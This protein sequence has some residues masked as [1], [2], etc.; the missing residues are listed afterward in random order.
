MSAKVVFV[1]GASGFLG[2]HIVEQLLSRGYRVRVSA[3]GKKAAIL[4][5][6]YSRNPAVE[7]FEISDIIHEQ[8][9]EALQGVDAVIHAASPLPG[10]ME[11]EQML[12]TAIEGSL[13]VLRQAE[14]AGVKRFVVTSSVA[15][16]AGNPN[17]TFKDTD[18]NPVT[19]EVAINAGN[20]GVTYAASK[21]FA[22]LA[23]TLL[24]N[25]P[26]NT[27]S[28]TVNPPFLYGPFTTNF[29]TPDFDAFST[30]LSIYNLIK[31][32][33]KYPPRPGYAD[34]RDVARAH[35]TA[36]DSPP[37]SEVGRKRVIFASPYDFNFKNAI[38][39]LSEK[40]P[41]LKGRL[42]T[43][44]PPELPAYRYPVDFERIERVTGLKKG[45]FH[46][47]EK[48]LLDTVDNLLDVEAGWKSQ[49]DSVGDI[50]SFAGV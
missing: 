2:S 21:K 34:V 6:T 13:N 1:S 3:R 5:T 26:H 20:D 23:F 41:Q 38:E 32:E 7:I 29:A 10:R 12:N 14:K 18:W 39:L 43:Q 8:F 30:N 9:P 45:D 35:V 50:P 46:T 16:L 24:R 17:G 31:T 42:I 33:G 47:F 27:E 49:G 44:V 11:P 19:K 40:R 28:S 36:L 37:T 4:K 25:M 22:E 48:T 15:T